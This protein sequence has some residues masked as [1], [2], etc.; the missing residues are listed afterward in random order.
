MKSMKP[1]FAVILILSI[2]TVM[3]PAVLV[4]PFRGEDSPGGKEYQSITSKKEITMSDLEESVLDVTVHR[5]G[6]GER[7]TMPLEQYIAG[8][9]AAEMPADFELEALK[10]QSLTARTYI[11]DRL[12]SGAKVKDA[13]VTD[14]IAHQVYQD[15]EQLRSKWGKH[16][17]RNMKKVVRAVYETKGK[18]LT[19]EGDP[20][21]AFFFSTSN[22]FTENSENYWE[23][24]LPYLKSVESPWD[25]ESPKYL[26]RKVISVDDF[27]KRL[28]VNINDSG[29]IGVIKGR[30][31]GNRVAA[32]SIGGKTLSGK[33]IR[34]ALELKST[35]FTWERKEDSII[36]TTK[37]YGHGVGMSQY[38]A[39][40]M[41]SEGK[42]YEEIVRHYYQGVEIASAEKVIAQ[43]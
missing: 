11:M 19:Y 9:V 26:D 1:F 2:V 22:G 10:A 38:G 8:V 4:L 29:N 18:I 30:T 7:L 37:G 39:N 25:K 12:I 6:T 17:E 24:S 5:S 20:I 41:A 40:G 33:K 15:E 28:G 3:I 32:V 13:D 27:E 36:I 43:K 34:E 14:T 16:Y 23:K 31:T 21:T 42:N 35:D